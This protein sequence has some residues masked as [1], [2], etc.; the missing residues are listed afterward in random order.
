MTKDPAPPDAKAGPEIVVDLIEAFR[1]SKAMFA[2]VEMGVFEGVRD[3]GMEFARLLEA[4]V[5][6]G[7]LEK[8]AGGDYVNTATA[9]E[10]LRRESPRTLTGYIR[11]SNAALYP[12]WANLEQAIREGGHRWAQTFGFEGS[13]IFIVKTDCS[14]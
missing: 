7:L 13:G 10:Y 6:L 4:C 3:G 5:A 8:T 9:D 1:R 11:Y 12:M 2:A 14:S